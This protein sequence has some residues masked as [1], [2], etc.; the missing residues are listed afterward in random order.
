MVYKTIVCIGEELAN[1][2]PHP[3]RYFEGGGGGGFAVTLKLIRFRPRSFYWRLLK[4]HS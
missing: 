1:Q 4:I 3:L 2:L